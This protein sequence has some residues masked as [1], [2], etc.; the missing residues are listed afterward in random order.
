MSLPRIP[1]AFFGIVLGVVG[2]GNSWRVAAAIWPVPASVGETI[3]L[4]GFATWLVLILL[5]AAK[6]FIAPKEVTSEL[7]H[8]IQC[9]FVGLIGVATMLAGLA[10]LPYSRIA[11]EVL[12][13]AGVAITLLFLLWRTGVVGVIRQPTRRSFICRLLPALSSPPLR[14]ARLVMPT[15][16]NSPSAPASFPGW[17]SNPYCCTGC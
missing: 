2:L 1:A 8:P 11:T 10:I 9:C 4:F 3:S 12:A 17:R 6:W 13:L 5:Y 7:E 14:Q 15:G 16:A